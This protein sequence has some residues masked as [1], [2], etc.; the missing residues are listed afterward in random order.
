MGASAASSV[1]S[2]EERVRATPA[3]EPAPEIPADLVTQTEWPVVL[4]HEGT[5]RY[6]RSRLVKKAAGWLVALGRIARLNPEL[7]GAIVDRAMAMYREQVEEEHPLEHVL[8]LRER[9]REEFLAAGG[10]VEMVTTWDVVD[11]AD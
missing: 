6:T 9:H 5:K 3:P 10:P 1:R 8:G 7:F 2:G 11:D 4:G